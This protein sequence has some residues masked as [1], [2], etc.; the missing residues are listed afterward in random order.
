MINKIVI[1]GYFCYPDNVDNNKSTINKYYTTGETWNTK[2]FK[3]YFIY[4]SLGKYKYFIL[5]KFKISTVDI[6]RGIMIPLSS[7][8]KIS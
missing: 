8:P 6:Y 2:V 3:K 4:S 1:I 5:E 7:P